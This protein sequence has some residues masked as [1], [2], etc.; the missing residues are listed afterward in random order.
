MAEQSEPLRRRVALKIIRLGMD[1]AEVIAR[2][3]IERQ[4]LALMDHPN[5]AKV[6]DAGATPA[7]RL[8]F[9]M[10]LVNGPKITDYCDQHKLTVEDRLRLFLLV[11]Q[12]LQHAHQKGIIHR[13]IKPSNILVSTQ[14]GR[15]VPKV[16]DFGI[17][18]ATGGRLTDQTLFTAYEQFF[19][20]P[21][22]MSPEQAGLG[23]LDIDTRSD[24]YSLGVLLYELLAGETPLD[25][26]SLSHSEM[27]EVRRQIRDVEP[28]RPSVRLAS[29]DRAAL[30]AIAQ[31]RQTPPARLVASLRG[32]L[33]WMVMKCLE[34]DRQRRYDNVGALATDIQRHLQNEPVSAGPPSAFYLLGKFA[35][36]HRAVL[37]TA[38]LFAGLLLGATAV[39]LWLAHQAELQ[40][41]VADEQR[42]AAQV[43]K[44]E[45]DKQRQIAEQQR[46][47]VQLAYNQMDVTAALNQLNLDDPNEAVAYVCRAL[48]TVPD[49]RAAASLLYSLLSE[50]SWLLPSAFF[51]ST[52]ITYDLNVAT[53]HLAAEEGNDSVRVFDLN[54]QQLPVTIT[55]PGLVGKIAFSADGR[56]LLTIENAN[57]RAPGGR[58]P[59]GP[60]EAPDAEGGQPPPPPGPPAEPEANTG[61]PP[62]LPPRENRGARGRG[63]FGRGFGR[64]VAG[65]V[66]VWD[67][68]TGHQ[69]SPTGAF[70]AVVSHAL[71]NADGLKILTV[72]GANVTLWDT[73]TGQAIGPTIVAPARVSAIFWTADGS[74]IVLAARDNTPGSPRDYVGVWDAATGQPISA[75]IRAD[76]TVNAVALSPDGAA[77]AAALNDGTAR[78]WNTATG[79]PLGEPMHHEAPVLTVAF[80]ADGHR[81]VTGSDDDTARVWSADVRD[82]GQP[83]SA[84]LRGDSAIDQAIFRPD[85]GNVIASAA[86][87]SIQQWDFPANNVSAA[88]N[89][90]GSILSPA[91][92]SADGRRMIALLPDGS[93]Q[94]WDTVTLQPI[95]ARLHREGSRAFAPQTLARLSPDGLFIAVAT[96]NRTVR[97]WNL[98][99]SQ[100]LSTPIQLDSRVRLF[101]FSD[102]GKRLVTADDNNTVR[103][104]D[105]ATG[106]SVTAP[107]S[108]PAR[109]LAVAFSADGQSVLT[110]AADHS[111]RLWDIATGE[112]VSSSVHLDNSLS[113]AA[114]SPDGQWLLAAD[115]P[116]AR[117]WNLA[118]GQPVSAPMPAGAPIAT[119]FFSPDGQRALTTSIDGTSRLWDAATGAPTSAPIRE[120][121]PFP[122]GGPNGTGNPFNLGT[123]RP[124]LPSPAW[125][126]TLLLWA[127]PAQP[128]P[129]VILDLAETLAQ[130]RIDAT[131]A[132]AYERGQ[133]LE[134]L[135]SEVD[136]AGKNSAEATNPFVAWA[137]NALGSDANAP[138]T[139]PLFVK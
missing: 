38:S 68:A 12:A 126:A 121:R 128:V 79:E 3:Q 7:G 103:V 132:P 44:Q 17:A 49:N 34:K 92:F 119:A 102:D 90:Y 136:D 104:W 115:G 22:Y 5:I 66:R 18:K 101:A 99:T 71:L 56:R 62:P 40:K 26:N 16:I 129:S 123:E 73:A 13:D 57:P 87:G 19:G 63:G 36:R 60:P 117:V 11:C 48:R 39:S 61:T 91:A 135:R 54:K 41:Q 124:N 118:D 95:S 130:C 75:P 59:G 8:F 37:A 97:V 46:R 113:A 10:E 76:A 30:A 21:A 137:R 51:T 78:L 100:P 96:D 32:D 4:A 120:G 94:V 125:D 69:I 53:G 9:V 20:T 50:Q 64:G 133:P 105:T 35:R 84:P 1:T 14:D 80:S 134:T 93:L 43:Q 74:K 25:A 70:P 27:D 67:A 45:A 72:A 15:P 83:L 47:A 55:T 107:L 81:L 29:L 77:F 24:I 127:A 33:D 98:A 6:L 31:K 116:T 65:P 109:I 112:S 42:Q 28:P 52:N 122:G 82:A 89:P 85:Y 106:Q 110:A 139:T 114:F 88:P 108:H 58:G 86:T 23:G 111:V 2:F 138:A 131:G